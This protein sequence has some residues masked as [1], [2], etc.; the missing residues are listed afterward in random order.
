MF[1]HLSFNNILKLGSYFLQ[2][3]ER[4]M[5]KIVRILTILSNY[6]SVFNSQTFDEIN[7]GRKAL[8]MGEKN[9]SKENG[10]IARGPYFSIKIIS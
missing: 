4:M 2:C 3:V 5:T 10:I 9:N 8:V 6:F 1:P 7:Q